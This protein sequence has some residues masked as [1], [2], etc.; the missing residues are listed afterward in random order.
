MPAMSPSEKKQSVRVDVEKIIRAQEH[1]VVRNLPRPVIRFIKW[2]IK[3]DE[4]NKGLEQFGHLKNF[5]FIEAILNYLNIKVE[6]YGT[7]NIPRDGNLIFVGNHAL[8]GPDFLALMHVLKDYFSKVNHLTNDVLM[9]IEPLKDFF[10][11]VKVFGKNPEKYRRLY[12]ERL[13]EPGVPTTIFPSGEVARYRNG[14]WDDGL[15]RSGFVRF[16][17]QYGKTVVPFYIPTKNSK[18][19]YAVNKWRR[20]LGIGANLELFLLPRE[21]LKMRNKTVRIYFGKPIPPEFFDDSK[22]V[23][24]WA[25]VVKK[26]VYQLNPEHGE[27]KETS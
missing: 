22:H 12:Y 18:L 7:E 5:D 6:A 19:F 16:A 15:W 8:G 26:M 10:L 13:S 4:I 2:L 20:R 3:E 9:G 17:K 1:P 14:R 24:E 11:P 23:H 25:D 21:L 27:K